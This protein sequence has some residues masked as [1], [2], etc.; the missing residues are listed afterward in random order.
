[1]SIQDLEKSIIDSFGLKGVIKMDLH[2]ECGKVPTVEALM[3]VDMESDKP[4]LTELKTF[5]L[6]EK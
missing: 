5:E 1:M 4:F 3:Y 6:V 2:L